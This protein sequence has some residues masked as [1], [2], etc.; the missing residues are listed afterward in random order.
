MYSNQMGTLLSSSCQLRL[1]VILRHLS[2]SSYSRAKY[3]TKLDVHWSFNNIQIKPR[4]K[5]KAAFHTNHRLFE[6]LVIFFGMT[7]SPATF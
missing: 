1:G 7:N 4:G 5:W 6:P 2:L 3:F